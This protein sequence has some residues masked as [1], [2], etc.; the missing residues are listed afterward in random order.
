MTCRKRRI[1]VGGCDFSLFLRVA[2][3]WRIPYIGMSV[4]FPAAY[5]ASLESLVP[6][7]VSIPGSWPVGQI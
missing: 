2:G 1:K 4:F 6:A 5:M 3:F 7:N